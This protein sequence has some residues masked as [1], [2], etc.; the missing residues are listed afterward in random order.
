VTVGD[1]TG[2]YIT[3]DSLVLNDDSTYPRCT[4]ASVLIAEPV[5]F[6]LIDTCGTPSYRDLIDSRL[7]ISILSLR[8]NPA[9]LVGGAARVALRFSVAAAGEVN[10]I[11]RDMLSRERSR[12]TI[13]C[14]PGV[15]ETEIEVPDA[16]E[17]T[18]FAE[19][20]AGRSHLVRKVLVERR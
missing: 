16:T 1:S 6:T 2:C 3:I 10:V 12:M 15:Q 9:P 20:I 13:A 4:L 7:N 11:V 19:L 18:Y 14:V 8:P 17:G 5:R